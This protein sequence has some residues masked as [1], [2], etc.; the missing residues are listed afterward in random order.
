MSGLLDKL[1]EENTDSSTG[2][3]YPCFNTIN[4]DQEPEY[5]NAEEV[6]YDLKPQ[7][8]NSEVIVSFMDSVESGKLRLLEKK[9][10]SDFDITDNNLT[11][12]KLPFVNTDFLIEEISNLKLKQLS[13]GKYTVESVV[14][15]MNKDRYSALAYILW[16]IN[17]FE[18]VIRSDNNDSTI[19]DYLIL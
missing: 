11:L 12:S 15:R 4:T 10:H 1:L 3:V 18:D 9:S 2:E 6:I 16:Y 13:N 8:A 17:K 5:D 19:F 7:S 14:K